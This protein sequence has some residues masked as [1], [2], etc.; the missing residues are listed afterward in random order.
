[1]FYANQGFGNGLTALQVADINAQRTK[2]TNTEVVNDIWG[3]AF[4]FMN[5]VKL[6]NSFKGDDKAYS[7]M[8]SAG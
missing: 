8:A 7:I 2:L 6:T 1:M 5:A 3:T 4:K